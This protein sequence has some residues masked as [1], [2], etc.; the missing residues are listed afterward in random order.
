MCKEL[1]TCALQKGGVIL[2]PRKK[3]SGTSSGWRVGGRFCSRDPHYPHISTYP[4]YLLPLGEHIFEYVGN[5][6]SALHAW[7][8]SPK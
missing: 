7:E 6:T 1:E 3:I 4:H 2:G 5:K 8:Q